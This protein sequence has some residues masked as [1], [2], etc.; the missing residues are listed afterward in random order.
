MNGKPDPD[1][2]RPVRC[3][4]LVLM[5]AAT[6]GAVGGCAT[7]KP[8][9]PA[10]VTVSDALR[11]AHQ[12][13]P[14]EE[15]IRRM[16]ASGTIYRLSASEFAS[17]EQQGLPAPV[18]DYMQ[19]TYLYAVRREQQLRDWRHDWIYGA[20]GYWYGGY[21]FGWPYAYW[22]DEFWE[23]YDTDHPVHRVL[24]ARHHRERGEH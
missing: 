1:R 15:I 24:Q 9:R 20:D 19:R 10:P 5:L 3:V 8:A 12:G 18:V 21:P 13:I 11:M 23:R 7:A 22:N 6:L 17:L 4:V 16:R 14:A 2:A